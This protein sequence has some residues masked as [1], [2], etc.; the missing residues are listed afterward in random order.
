MNFFCIMKNAALISLCTAAKQ[1]VQHHINATSQNIK[2]RLL[3]AS[4]RYEA[5]R[6]A[7]RTPFCLF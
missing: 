5:E 7:T 3:G 4:D 2:E 6:L 1:W